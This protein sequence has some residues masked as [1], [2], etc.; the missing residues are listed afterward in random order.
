MTKIYVLG[1]DQ[2][3]LPLTER[4]VQDGAL[5]NIAR[6][7]ERGSANRA[8]CS[9]PAWTPTNWATLSTGANTGTHGVFG[10]FVDM[11]EGGP[12]TSFDSHAVSA[13]T[14]WEAAERVGLSSAVFHY[15]ASMPSDLK[16]SFIV[17]GFASPQHGSTPY[18]VSSSR[19]YTNLSDVANSDKLALKSA[20]GWENLP[21]SCL[22]PLEASLWV[23]AKEKTLLSRLGACDVDPEE[24]MAV[25]AV[26][27]ERAG[28]LEF[29]LLVCASEP[30]MYDHV[31][32]CPRKDA[33]SAIAELA[34]GEWTDWLVQEMEVAGVPRRCTMRFKLIE[35]SPDARRL[36]L[37]RSQIMPEEGF[38][39]P[40]DLGSELVRLFGPYQEHVSEY[41]HLCGITDFQTC[42]EEAEYQLQWI[43]RTGQYL[44]RERG[45]DLFY[46]HW[47]FLDDINHHHLGLIDPDGPLY[48][49]DKAEFHWDKVRRAYQVID[50]AVGFLLQDMDD[51]TYLFVVSD[52]GC[53]P[54]W[55]E[56]HLE[57]FL[58]E[59]GF[60]VLKEEGL[61]L[62]AHDPQWLS[63]ID[64]G[65]TG[66]YVREGFFFGPEIYIN[67]PED[68]K[69][70]IQEQVIQAL[71]SWR[72]EESGRSPIAMALKKQ[73]AGLLGY[74]GDDLGDI[75][76]VTDGHYIT[77]RGESPTAIT[78]AEGMITGNHRCQLLTFETSLCSHMAMILATGPN[79][80]LGYT[81]PANRLGQL[82]LRDLV[83]T[84][85]HI[86]GIAP[87]AQSEGR[88]AY[89]LFSG[90]ESYREKRPPSVKPLW[91]EED[92][93]TSLMARRRDS[94]RRGDPWRD[95]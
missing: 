58:W 3:I 30:D 29:H 19:G 94:E 9:Y 71:L 91:T 20:R 93:R 48:D 80:K 54:V 33:N 31:L 57:R 46:C 16:Y 53:V 66:A 41:S 85:C 86:L 70:P 42:I 6:L 50:R 14:I 23:A 79:I 83:P 1:I 61:P 84:L 67:A 45:A 72:D 13:E 7:F 92:Q 76:V 75:V 81:R 52:H 17:D 55:Y 44:L 15:P 49:P 34:V 18:E 4:L 36:R 62:N 28:G 51:D 26:Q 35:L 5:P 39:H 24:Q 47:H 11:P 37:Y 56:I 21:I 87:P 89:D 74:W 88:V 10:W 12:I 73:D 65:K 95:D 82:H 90:H 78:K 40:L 43:V 68:E 59:Q 63:Y 60:L 32:I 8:I 2:M 77:G 38:T 64:W 27:A 22:A 25:E 69:E